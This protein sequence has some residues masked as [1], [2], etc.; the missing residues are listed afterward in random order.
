MAKS[1]EELMHEQAIARI[2][3]GESEAQV[4]QYLLENKVEESEIEVMIIDAK[5]H[6]HNMIRMSGI[7]SIIIGIVCIV[8]GIIA[9][10]FFLPFGLV[11]IFGM[12]K[13][14]S[15]GVS[16]ISANFQHGDIP[17]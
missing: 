5:R 2:M 7:K 10:L 1:R 6:R 13:L 15:G 3:W 14:I 8:L 17:R 16:L 9:M 4:R 11:A 12:Y